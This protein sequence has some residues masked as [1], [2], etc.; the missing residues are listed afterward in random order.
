M[1]EGLAFGETFLKRGWPLALL[2]RALESSEKKKSNLQLRLH[3]PLTPDLWELLGLRIPSHISCCRSRGML[4]FRLKATSRGHLSNAVTAYQLQ[5]TGTSKTKKSDQK[6]DDLLPNS[7]VWKVQERRVIR[8]DRPR[9][10][11]YGEC[12]ACQSVVIGTCGNAWIL[13]QRAG[14]K[15]QPL[16][17]SHKGLVSSH[18]ASWSLHGLHQV[19]GPHCLP[20][21]SQMFLKD[22]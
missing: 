21:I 12:I 13:T 4:W 14:L 10:G 9:T 19:D 5:G 11:Q 20:G 1:K 16:N 22:I 6:T 3:A 2:K 15:T 8:L 7:I 17:K 18:L